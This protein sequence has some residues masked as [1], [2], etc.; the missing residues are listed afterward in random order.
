MGE[1]VTAH[2]RTMVASELLGQPDD[3]ALGAA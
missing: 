3:D 1:C 2:A